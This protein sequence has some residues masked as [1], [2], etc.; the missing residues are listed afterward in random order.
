MSAPTKASAIE[1]VPTPTNI[2]LKSVKVSAS[3]SEE[4]VAFTATIYLDGPHKSGRP[5]KVGEVRNSG[6]GGSHLIHVDPAHR[7]AFDAEVQRWA[8]ESGYKYGEPADAVIDGLVE[9]HQLVKSAKSMA[10]KGFPVVLLVETGGSQ[11]PWADGE[12]LYDEAYIVGVR[13]DG[14]TLDEALATH[15]AERFR[16]LIGGAS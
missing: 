11:P 5:V 1:Y 9:H 3:L 15:K 8:T 10:R 13:P 16:Y 4:T 14:M 7:G 12:T 6:T 2:S